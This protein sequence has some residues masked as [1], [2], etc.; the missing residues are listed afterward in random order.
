MVEH[1]DIRDAQAAREDDGGTSDVVAFDQQGIAINCRRA[2]NAE[3]VRGRDEDAVPA[4]WQR[5]KARAAG[6]V[7]RHRT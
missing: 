7:D 2:S 4:E 5:L 1:K 3:R 6:R